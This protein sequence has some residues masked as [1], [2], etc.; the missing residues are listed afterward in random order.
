[1]TANPKLKIE[2]SGHTDDVGG[3]TANQLLSENRAKAVVDYLKTKN[4]PETRLK[5]HGYGEAQPVTT[6][7]TVEGRTL[8]WRTE[9]K[10]LEN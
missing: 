1:M 5:F 9:F 6:N 7:E 4:I 8:N 10:I 3:D 2:I